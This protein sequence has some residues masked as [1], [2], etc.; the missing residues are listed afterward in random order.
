MKKPPP[1]KI[2]MGPAYGPVGGTEA[3]LT[4]IYSGDE[5]DRDD[6]FSRGSKSSMSDK[7]RPGSPHFANLDA[8]DEEEFKQS[9]EK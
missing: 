7:D 1:C 9:P 4:E 5:R 3:D 2:D 6:L 8:I